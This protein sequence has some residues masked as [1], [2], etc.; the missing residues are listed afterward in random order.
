MIYKNSISSISN[1]NIL[2][3]LLYLLTIIGIRHK[4]TNA[5]SGP[6]AV[7]A[8]KSFDTSDGT[9]TIDAEFEPSTNLLS[10]AAKY[11][12]NKLR[13]TLG[14]EGNNKDKLQSVSVVSSEVVQGS[15]V[16]ST[17]GYD[18]QVLKYSLFPT[19]QSHFSFPIHSCF[20]ITYTRLYAMLYVMYYT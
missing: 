7:F 11:V 19:S 15:T 18:L 13:V 8:K 2:Y 4:F 6:D 9:A 12:S 16:K 20:V 5:L 1:S 14:A 3:L 17:V 10:V